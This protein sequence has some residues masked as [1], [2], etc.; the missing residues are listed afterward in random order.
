MLFK[1]QTFIKTIEESEEKYSAKQ[2]HIHNVTKQLDVCF[3]LLPSYYEVK[4]EKR[5]REKEREREREGT[6]KIEREF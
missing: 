5:E 6:R 3:W 2:T 4:F 1:S